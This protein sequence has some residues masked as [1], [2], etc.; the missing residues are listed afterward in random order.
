MLLCGI[1]K[2]LHLFY[3]NTFFSYYFKIILG[4]LNRL[5]KDNRFRI[6]FDMSFSSISTILIKT[7]VRF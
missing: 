5:L 7:S 6:R 1:P 4:V 2:M 3:S